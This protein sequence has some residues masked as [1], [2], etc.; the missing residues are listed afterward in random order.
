MMY[1][2]GQRVRLVARSVEEGTVVHQWPQD[3]LVEVRWD[4][5]AKSGN[6]VR[7]H[8]PNEIEPAPARRRN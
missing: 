6:A 2:K 3:Q 4:S 8:W 5:L 1:H 7:M